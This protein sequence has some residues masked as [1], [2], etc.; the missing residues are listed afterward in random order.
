MVCS[1]GKVNLFGISPRE[2]FPVILCG[3]SKDF[4]TDDFFGALAPHT[5]DSRANLIPAR[6]EH[7]LESGPILVG[8]VAFFGKS[9]LLDIA[10][11]ELPDGGI[12][13]R[14]VFGDQVEL[15]NKRPALF[16]SH[17]IVRYGDQ[18]LGSLST[19][20]ALSSVNNRMKLVDEV[21]A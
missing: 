1:R 4:K 15:L 17:N 12:D 8:D 19:Y 10:A 20:L 21:V 3:F 14:V 16:I 13:D 2:L 9:Y 6:E 11:N 5:H 7:A 18:M